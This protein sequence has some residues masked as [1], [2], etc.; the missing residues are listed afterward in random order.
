MSRAESLLWLEVKAVALL[1]RQRKL[2]GWSKG[3]SSESS[4]EACCYDT[5]THKPKHSHH[6]HTHTHT[7]TALDKS[8]ATIIT[9]FLHKTHTHGPKHTPSD[10]QLSSEAKVRVCVCVFV[11]VCL[12]VSVCVW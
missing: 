8:P 1:R 9:M 7:H 10:T 12:C 6:T 2:L 11:C 4:A 3:L 5:H